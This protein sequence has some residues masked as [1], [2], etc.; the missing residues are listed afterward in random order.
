MAQTQLTAYDM[1]RYDRQIM[2]I[3]EEGQRRLKDARVMVA[4]VG[5]LGSPVSMYLAVAG[6]GKIRLVD[7]DSVDLSNLNRQILHWDE[8][9][10]RRK[11]E[12]ARRK[13][14]E[15]NPSVSVESIHETITEE[16]VLDLVGDAHA[17]VDCMDNFAAR[18]ALNRAACEKGI[19]FFHGAV[20]GMEARATTILP[21][22]TACF[23][24]LYPS[25]PPPERFPVLGA[26]PG[27]AAMVQVMEVVK[28]FSGT[29]SL[30]K[31][32]LLMFDG[33]T[34]RCTEVK[35]RRNPECPDCGSLPRSR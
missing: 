26:A 6:I 18:Y 14:G 34:A 17:I 23:R 24:C 31:D 13:L 4:G 32:R 8:D 12:S 33:E 15:A 11:V 19:P 28:Y 5:G 9:I 25:G 7:N 29:G 16:N 1:E 3:G 22:E 35:L 30:L 2:L 27:L 10:G 21:G 20:Y